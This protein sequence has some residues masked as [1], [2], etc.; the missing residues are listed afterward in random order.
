[1]RGIGLTLGILLTL[2]A[3][4][5]VASVVR[6][7]LH[8]RRDELAIMHLVGAPQAFVN[9]PFIMEGT[10]QG[11]AGALLA[12]VTLGVAFVILRSR[13]L[14]PLASAVSIS[15]FV[16]LSPLACLAL[17]VG[18]MAV[19]C[20]GGWFAATWPDSG[21]TPDAPISAGG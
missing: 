20:L 7:T 17:V 8:A 11:G 14:S 3:A 1:V 21:R 9:G 4:L 16:F 6:L 13:Y 18:G 15:P 5:T 19:G 12:V 10:I 2:A